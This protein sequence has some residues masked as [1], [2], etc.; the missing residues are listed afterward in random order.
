MK[1]GDG[2]RF[3]TEWVQEGKNTG[4]TDS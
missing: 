1:S 3:E 2:S 4:M